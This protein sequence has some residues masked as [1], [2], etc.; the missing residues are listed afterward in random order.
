VPGPWDLIVSNLP[1]K[2]GEPVLADFVR[3]AVS[4]LGPGGVAAVVIVEPLAAWFSAE[5]DRAGVA[6]VY[7]EAASGYRVFHFGSSG[8]VPA[9]LGPPFPAAYARG[10]TA[11]SVGPRSL[12]LKTFYGLPNF[13]SLDFRLQLTFGVL[14]GQVLRG[15]G[16]VWEPGQGHLA[17]WADAVLPPGGDLHLAGNDLLALEAAREAVVRRLASLHPVARLSEVALGPGSLS[18]ALVQ[19]YP[20]PEVPWVEEARGALLRLLA[21]GARAVVNGSSTDLTR[22]LERHQGL[23]KVSDGRA[24]GWRVVVLE[25]LG[26]N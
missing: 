11:W 23:R 22:F 9:P 16:L 20:E 18:W 6:R 1:A 4:L 21:P 26:V 8:S 14:A 19:L 7:E 17:A 10:E 3:R 5:L 24:K 12:S 13:D 25:R 15:D 2:A